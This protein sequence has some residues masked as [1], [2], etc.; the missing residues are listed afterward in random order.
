[1]PTCRRVTR[2]K[3]G[4]CAVFAEPYFRGALFWEASLRSLFRA[5][6]LRAVVQGRL[7]GRSLAQRIVDPGDHPARNGGASRVFHPL[8]H[9]ASECSAK[10]RSAT[11]SDSQRLRGRTRWDGHPAWGST[12]GP[13]L[14]TPKGESAIRRWGKRRTAARAPTS[15]GSCV[16]RPW[17]RKL[18]G[19]S[20]FYDSGVASPQSLFPRYSFLRSTCQTP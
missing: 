19:R 4:T 7:S 18:C 11:R 14:A 1:M 2:I 17:Q 5:T 16:G 10:G 9:S 6:T 3:S 20:C 13:Y 15:A 12:L 8:R